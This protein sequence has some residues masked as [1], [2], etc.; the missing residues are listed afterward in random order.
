MDKIKSFLKEVVSGVPMGI[1]M[2]AAVVG[3]ISLVA[4]AADKVKPGVGE[5]IRKLFRVA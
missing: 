1:A 2:L 4:W 5:M 3:V